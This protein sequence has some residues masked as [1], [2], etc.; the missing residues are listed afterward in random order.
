MQIFKELQKSWLG[1]LITVGIGALGL[2]ISN[3]SNQP[4]LDP[5]V[6][7]MGSGI[8][9]RAFCRFPENILN[10]F[11]ITPLICLPP[12]IA[13]YGAVNLNF[14]IASFIKE[15]DFI[16]LLLVVCLV[17]IL[18]ALLLA[19]LF[20]LK[21][22]V[23]YLIASG[24]AICGA[25]AIAITSRAI[26]AEPDDVSVSLTAVFLSALIGLFIILPLTAAY[27][28]ISGIDYGVFSGAVLQF[29]GFVK[30]AVIGLPL[31]VQNMAF[32]IKALRYIGLLFIIPLFSSLI[33]GKLYTPW[34]LWVFLLSGILFSVIPDLA[35]AANPILKPTLN[36][37]WSI[38][39]AGIGLNADIRKLGTLNGIKALSVSFLAFLIAVFT[40]IA[41]GHILFSQMNKLF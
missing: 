34:Y 16:V 12:G 5:L 27:F 39:M 18:A 23:G 11:K 38:A 8:V 9:L 30:S 13:I 3:M 15:V 20:N 41:M 29:T 19:N 33:K 22:K 1:F 24:S 36:I 37:L 32:S 14:Q 28:K 7:A 25:S 31:E 4:I 17:Y 26:D 10:G 2:M 6:M 21:E 35:V 40:F